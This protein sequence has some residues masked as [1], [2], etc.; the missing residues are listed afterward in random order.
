MDNKFLHTRIHKTILNII[1]SHNIKIMLFTHNKNTKTNTSK[2]N[3]TSQMLNKASKIT[4]N[5]STLT[6]N[7]KNHTI[8]KK[9]IRKCTKTNNTIISLKRP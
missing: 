6:N 7:T 4:N 8:S 9:M 1:T 5:I 2:I 3:N